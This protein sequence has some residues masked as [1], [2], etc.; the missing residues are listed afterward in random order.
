MKKRIGLLAG[1]ALPITFDC[2]AVSVDDLFSVYQKHAQL[3]NVAYQLKLGHLLLQQDS[4]FYDPDQALYWFQQAADKGDAH[5]MY[6]V[7]EHYWN[8]G[9]ER[10]ELLKSLSLFE[11]AATLGDRKAQRRLCSLA[12]VNHAGDDCRPA[13]YV[14]DTPTQLLLADFYRDSGLELGPSVALYWY[15]AA[16]AQGKVRA[17]RAIERLAQENVPAVLIRSHLFS[18]R[19]DGD[20]ER[21]DDQYRLAVD[22]DNPENIFVLSLLYL[23]GD[24]VQHSEAKA[25]TLLISAA[26]KGY[27]NAQFN[28]G[29]YYLYGDFF[30]EVQALIDQD[31]ARYWLEL[32]SEQGV[33][34]A[35]DLLSLID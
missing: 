27:H 10:A 5:G 22:E 8:E 30:G 23:Y 19:F 21:F 32:A 14:T 2:L 11:Q 34:A 12:P 16:A 13:A 15:T 20:M 35:K 24:V 17:L 28:L 7:A 6:H 18:G 1:L 4:N 9:S 31:R 29:Q 3:G 33:E 25:L 26:E